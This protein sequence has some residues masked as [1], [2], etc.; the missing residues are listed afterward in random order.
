MIDL[1]TALDDCLTR[2]ANGTA[3]VDDCLRLYPEH[4]AEL[5]RMLAAA[6]TLERGRA[7][8]PSDSFKADARARLVAHMKA[9]PRRRAQPAAAFG[10]A[11]RFGLAALAVAIASV[12]AAQAALPGNPL[13]SLKL[14]TESV[15]RMAQPNP[16]AADLALADRRAAEL[17]QT[18]PGSPA[19]QLALQGY[20]RALAQLAR[21]TSPADRATIMNV[22]AAQKEILSRV[23]VVVPALEQWI[24][25]TPPATSVAPTPVVTSVPTLPAVV[26]PTVS[27]Q[28][29]VTVPVLTALPIVA[30]R[31]LVPPVIVTAL[32][33][34]LPGNPLPT[35]P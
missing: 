12:S 33:T 14:V 10:W 22:L 21:Y 2:L 32:P 27:G 35:P 29:T 34:A 9:N 11:L 26:L 6:S 15:W 7:V 28:P 16:L 17:A 4:A 13:Y 20:E 18:P 19:V 8:R 25:V 30:T 23:D 24:G 1:D 3:T 31:T 5:R